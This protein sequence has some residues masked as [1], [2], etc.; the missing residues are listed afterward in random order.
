M[1]RVVELEVGD[2]R[3]ARVMK[4]QRA[5]TL[6]RLGDQPA[7]LPDPGTGAVPDQHR[8]V[9]P[10]GGQDL[11]RHV[12]RGGLPVSAGHRD[13]TRR[14]G[15]EVGQQLGPAQRSNPS[16][17]RRRQLGVAGG[18]RRGVDEQVLAAD[19][20][21]VVADRDLDARGCQQLGRLRPF[22]IAP[23]YLVASRQ[24]D[25]GQRGHAGASD[26]HQ[27]NLQRAASLR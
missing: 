15:Q 17:P 20:S 8:R 21:R 6:V 16:S 11:A 19:M 25:L 24:Q 7:A 9:E 12:R 13:R 23:A 22:E 18:H 5:V 3:V 1:V 27:V 4:D 14:R 26:A 10:T 2:D